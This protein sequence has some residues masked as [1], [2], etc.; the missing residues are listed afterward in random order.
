MIKEAVQ[1]R[2]SIACG[3]ERQDDLGGQVVD[4]FWDEIGE[5]SVLRMIPDLL[6]G[7]EVWRIGRKPFDG[8]AASLELLGRGPVH[9]EAIPDQED[10][11]PAELA[12]QR[13]HE[14]LGIDRVNVVV[15][16]S[17]VQ[18]DSLP[19]RRD[20]QYAD[21]REPIVAI[22]TAQDRRV[23]SRRPRPPHQR[24]EHEAALIE[25]DDGSALAARFFLSPANP[26]GETPR[27]RDRRARA[28]IAPAFV[29]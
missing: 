2:L 19:F 10:L 16:N 15:M 17:E 7:I 27:P 20:C 8:D 3:A 24:L 28:P 13:P 18:T 1:E 21:H 6:D 4:V 26:F 12:A 11:A 5:L 14:V 29:R 23:P 22:P 9:I 25:Q